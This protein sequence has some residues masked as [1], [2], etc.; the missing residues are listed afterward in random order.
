MGCCVK[1]MPKDSRET[2]FRRKPITGTSLEHLRL[3]LE[4]AQLN[5]QFI[6]HH[7]K[8]PGN[9]SSFII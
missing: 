1:E 9:I 7:Y 8:S 5:H 3:L 2:E 6:N 4:E